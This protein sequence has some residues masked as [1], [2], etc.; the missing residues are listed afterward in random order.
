M[1]QQVRT[2][3]TGAN[4]KAPEVQKETTF[5]TVATTTNKKEV[6]NRT[7][8]ALASVR[9][10][11]VRKVRLTACGTY[12]PKLFKGLQCALANTNEFILPSCLC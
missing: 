6:V 9:T 2:S 5:K 12:V 8:E 7:V 11:Q 1:G 4:G 10:K 3:D